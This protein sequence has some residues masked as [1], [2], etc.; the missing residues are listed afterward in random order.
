MSSNEAALLCRSFFHDQT[1]RFLVSG[2][3][4]CETTNA[5]WLYRQGSGGVYPRLNGGYRRFPPTNR[6]SEF[7]RNSRHALG[8]DKPRH[9]M[10][11]AEEPVKTN[12]AL[13]SY[14]FHFAQKAQNLFQFLCKS[15][16]YRRL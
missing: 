16:V 10:G 2:R 11:R 6:L 13:D 1:G 12:W 5:E 3:R 8:G 14:Q 9:Y 4:L 15:V 7:V